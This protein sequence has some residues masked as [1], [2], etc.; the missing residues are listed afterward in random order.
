MANEAIFKE[1]GNMGMYVMSLG[2]DSGLFIAGNGTILTNIS[3]LIFS[4][5]VAVGTFL[6]TSYLMERKIDL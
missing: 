1:Y 6:G 4:I 3:T 5:L 2:T